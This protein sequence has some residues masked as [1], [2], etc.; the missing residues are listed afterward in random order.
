MSP[1]EN[2]FFWISWYSGVI[3]F[4]RG[5]TH[6]V[7]QLAEFAEPLP[8]LGAACLYGHQAPI[9]YEVRNFDGEVMESRQKF[10]FVIA[11]RHSSLCCV[12]V[13]LGFSTRG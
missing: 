11:T 13:E 1:T 5:Q 9:T 12:A 8:V 4:G 7:D 3:R 10:A 2:R 6:G